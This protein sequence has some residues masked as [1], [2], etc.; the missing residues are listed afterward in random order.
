MM[1]IN[2]GASVD[3]RLDLIETLDS[4]YCQLQDNY[5]QGSTNIGFARFIS[6]SVAS[7]GFMHPNSFNVSPALLLVDSNTLELKDNFD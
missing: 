2:K 6:N 1:D 5:D 3:Q 7:F 4:L